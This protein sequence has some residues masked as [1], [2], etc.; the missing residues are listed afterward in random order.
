MP[1]QEASSDILKKPIDISVDVFLHEGE[2]FNFLVL[3]RHI[4]DVKLEVGNFRFPL[5]FE[6]LST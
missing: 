4:L 1:F 6:H 2:H 5:S 3:A